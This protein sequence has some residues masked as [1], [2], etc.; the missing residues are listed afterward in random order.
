MKWL[1]AAAILIAGDVYLSGQLLDLYSSYLLA[2]CYFLLLFIGAFML[3][4]RKN[5]LAKDFDQALRHYKKIQTKPK[6][7]SKQKNQATQRNLQPLLQMSLALLCALLL[8]IPGVITSLIGIALSTRRT[9]VKITSRVIDS[10]A[11]MA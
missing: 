3:Y 11:N 9:S 7:K 4:M 10:Q 2:G 5:G 6:K 8:I 1:L